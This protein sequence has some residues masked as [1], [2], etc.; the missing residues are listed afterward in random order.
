MRS[1]REFFTELSA[2]VIDDLHTESLSLLLQVPSNAAHS[3]NSQSLALGI[4]AKACRWLTSP[5][6]FSESVHAS[7]EVAKGAKNEEHIHI[8][9]GVIHGRRHIRDEER[10]VTG[11]A[12][13]DIYLVVASAC[14]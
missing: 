3:Q 4:V 5:L 11:T 14:P 10:G 1:T 7:I 12:C 13:V 2:I 6:S 9:S 8:G